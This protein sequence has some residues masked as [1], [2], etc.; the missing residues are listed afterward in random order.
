M[1]ARHVQQIFIEGMRDVEV[2]SRCE[3]DACVSML[4]PEQRPNLNLYLPIH[5]GADVVG[6]RI[7]ELL[8]SYDKGRTEHLKFMKSELI[9]AKSRE[10][11]TVGGGVGPR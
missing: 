4:P 6:Q 5:I 1:L 9:A 3:W 8:E 10:R 11:I 2:A 7:I